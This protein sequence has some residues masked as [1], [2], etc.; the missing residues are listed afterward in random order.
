MMIKIVDVHKN[1]FD[2]PPTYDLLDEVKK[3]IGMQP[4]FCYNRFVYTYM[5]PFSK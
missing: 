1:S 4:I 5:K 2:T 3:Y